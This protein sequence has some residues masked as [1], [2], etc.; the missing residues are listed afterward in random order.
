MAYTWAQWLDHLYICYI[1]LTPCKGLH[2]FRAG[3]KI[4][5]GLD[6]GT[7]ATS[8]LP[9]WGIPNASEQQRKMRNGTQMG[10]LATSPLPSWGVP[11]ALEHGRKLEATHTWA[12]GLHHPCCLWGVTNSPDWGTTSKVAPNWAYW[13]HHPCHFRGSPTI[14]SGEQNRKS[15]TRGNIDYLTLAVVGDPQY[16]RGGNQITGGLHVGA[17]ARSPLHSLHHPY[18]S[19]RTSFTA[20]DHI[21]SGLHGT[22]WLQHPCCLRGLPTIFSCRENQK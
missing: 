18:P 14:G 7:L 8:P 9:S 11:D 22:H 19:L 12:F 6:V 10:T 5:S 3:D 15:P 2:S 20:G 17:L 1:T 13:P 4:T 21:R 16:L